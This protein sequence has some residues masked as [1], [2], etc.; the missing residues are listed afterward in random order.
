MTNKNETVEYVCK[1]MKE[2]SIYKGRL[3]ASFFDGEF[4]GF[5]DRILD[6][7]NREIAE[8]KEQVSIAKKAFFKIS[9]CKHSQAIHDIFCEAEFMMNHPECREGVTN[10]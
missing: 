7:H 2:P 10:D 8:L 9:Q 6:A 3:P 4:C 5:A 1:K